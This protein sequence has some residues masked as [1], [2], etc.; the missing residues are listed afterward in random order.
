MC[1]VWE[2][3]EGGRRNIGEFLFLFR[4]PQAPSGNNWKWIDLG[5]FGDLWNIQH[6]RNKEEGIKDDA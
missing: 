5:I 4:E 3:R 2:G 6:V 1:S